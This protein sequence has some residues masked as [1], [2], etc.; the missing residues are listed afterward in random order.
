VTGRSAEQGVEPPFLSLRGVSKR[1]GSTPALSE[2]DLHVARDELLVILGP[3]GAGKTTLLRTI[4]GLLVPDRGSIHLGETDVTRWEPAQRDVALVFQNFSLYPR[5]SVRKNLEFP[6][7]AP[8]RN[9]TR[10]TIRER[11]DWAAELLQITRL[12]E[13]DASRLS[14]G[15]MQRVAI[16]R[17]IVRRPRLFLMDEPLTNLDAKLREAL[18][19]ELVELRRQL[20]TPMV[21][22]THDQSEALSMADRIVVLSEGR[23][24]QEGTP[25]DI[26][27]RPISPVV[28][29]QLGQP[30]INLIPV[31]RVS[32]HWT[33]LDGT[34]LMAAEPSGPSERL[35]G[36]RPEDIVPEPLGSEPG[37]VGPSGQEALVQLVEYLGP[38]TTLL[39]QWAGTQVHISLARRSPFRPNDRL[40]LRVLPARAVLFDVHPDPVRLSS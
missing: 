19:V 26:Y 6:L 21:F 1:L 5:W 12:L 9:L 3:T 18:R 4:A 8:G 29:R 11:V 34:A 25:R 23:V 13:R 36:I 2:I 33:A 32:G 15:E 14:G 37:G 27:A 39:C 20:A 30:A 10:A 7:R 28:A 16:G 31:R 24:L 40:R 38:T 22:V 17:A 35:L